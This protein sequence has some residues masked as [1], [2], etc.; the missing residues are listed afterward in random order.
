MEH[1]HDDYFSTHF[2]SP[3]TGK[4]E[5]NTIKSTNDN[6]A[7]QPKWT[8]FYTSNKVNIKT[9]RSSLKEHPFIK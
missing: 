9:T 1:Q 4:I 7:G 3:L 8:S 2:V 6:L 5:S